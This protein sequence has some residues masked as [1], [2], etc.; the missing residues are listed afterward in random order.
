MLVT[1]ENAGCPFGT[2]LGGQA[3]L[4]NRIFKKNTKTA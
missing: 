3:V 4:G 2:K 1:G